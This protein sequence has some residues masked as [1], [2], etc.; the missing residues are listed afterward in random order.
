MRT[1]LKSGKIALGL[2]EV[3][4]ELL[5]GS[6]F[7]LHRFKFGLQRA[8]F[9][10]VT[11]ISVMK[12]L[13]IYDHRSELSFRDCVMRRIFPILLRR[14]P[15]IKIVLASMKTGSRIRISILLPDSL[16]LIFSS[17]HCPPLIGW[18]GG[19]ISLNNYT[20][21]GRFITARFRLTV[22]RKKHSRWFQ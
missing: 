17:V 14:K 8:L 21:H 19:I 22:C 1:L 10:P 13:R 3:G 16:W 7:S 12:A 4:F 2:P 11:G 18:S 6:I 15:N 9:F 20:W 5:Y